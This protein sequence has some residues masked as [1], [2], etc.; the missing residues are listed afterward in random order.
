MTVEKLQDQMTDLADQVAQTSSQM[1]LMM[2]M[3]QNVMVQQRRN[4]T[5]LDI[6]EIPPPD[7]M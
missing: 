1:T 6:T 2:Q 4:Q 5:Q 3:M 7:D